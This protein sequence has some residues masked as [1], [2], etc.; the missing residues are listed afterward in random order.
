VVN[1]GLVNKLTLS[2]SN[3]MEAKFAQLHATFMNMMA[4]VK[5]NASRLGKANNKKDTLFSSLYVDPR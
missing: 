4:Q 5:S 2:Q 3:T 1:K